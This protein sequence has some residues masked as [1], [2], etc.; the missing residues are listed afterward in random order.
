MRF[1]LV[2]LILLAGTAAGPL[3]AQSSDRIERRVEKLE[4]DVAAVQRRVTG[5]Y[6]QPEIMPSAPTAGPLGNPASNPV[7]DLTARVDS[8]EAQLARLTGASEENANRMRQ[9]EGAFSEYRLATD[10]RLEELG[11]APKAAPSSNGSEN[12]SAAPSSSAAASEAAPSGDP[13]EDAYLAG[14]RQ[15][16]G[17]QLAAAQKTLEAMAK[18]YPKHRRASYALNLAGRAYLDAGQPATAAKVL[19]AN[20]QADA[21]GERAADSLYFLGQALVEL[22][23]PTNA[24]KVYEELQSVYGDGM[25]DWL[26]Q[27]LPKARQDA[28]C[29]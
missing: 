15:W 24:C 7:A 10:R 21:K 9:L 6:V 26:K 16:E 12:A 29:S 13:A 28:K 8:L 20:Y 4:R 19:L 5:N 18:K 1:H 11:Q 14:F 3:L 17:G 25:R 22:K 2:G 23:K 27:R